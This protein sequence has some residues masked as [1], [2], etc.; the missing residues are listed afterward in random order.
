VYVPGQLSRLYC[1]NSG[2][3]SLFITSLFRH[4][5]LYPCTFRVH[6]HGFC[7][8]SCVR[9]RSITYSGLLS[10]PYQHICLNP[11]TSRAMCFGD[12]TIFLCIIPGLLSCH[13]S[14]LGMFS[15][16]PVCAGRGVVRLSSFYS[17]ILRV[18]IISPYRR[19]LLVPLCFGD[20]TVFRLLL[21]A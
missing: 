8:I 11:G 13:I 16:Y 7:R 1:R 6:C 15:W 17:G 18:I 4:V 12:Y 20:F 21:W 19:V 3:R 9:S 14:H 2:V 5:Y 10:A